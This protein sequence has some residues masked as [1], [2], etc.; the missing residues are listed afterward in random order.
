LITAETA[1]RLR[2]DTPMRGD[3]LAVVSREPQPDLELGER[4]NQR[5]RAVLSGLTIEDIPDRD[6][7]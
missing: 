4:G 3:L 5:K 1:Q 7:L 2:A 6:A